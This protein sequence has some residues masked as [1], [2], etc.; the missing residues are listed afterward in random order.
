MPATT[1][2]GCLALCEYEPVTVT[3]IDA[4]SNAPIQ[5]AQVELHYISVSCLNP[6]GPPELAEAMSG[7]TRRGRVSGIRGKTTWRSTLWARGR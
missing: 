3:V 1:L 5:G 7:A 4:E 2:P 6:P